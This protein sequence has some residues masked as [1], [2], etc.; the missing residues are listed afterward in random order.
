MKNELNA[1]IKYDRKQDGYCYTEEGFSLNQ[2]PLN[3][4]EIEALD[5]STALLGLIK[6]SPL[7]FQFEN[8]IN[9][10][11][12]GY[13]ISKIDGVN[14][15]QFLQTEM[16]LLNNDGQWLEPILKAIISQQLLK[17]EYQSFGGEKK[18]HLLSPY[19]LKEYRNRWYVA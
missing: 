3:H 13:R 7:F 8:A 1:P 14:Q 6:G 2:F 9:K 12:E 17:V 4:E 11:I 19:V 15:S 10:V 5:F 18:E 16:P